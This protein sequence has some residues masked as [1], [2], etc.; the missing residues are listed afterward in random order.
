[1]R[2]QAAQRVA[3]DASGAVMDYIVAA[4]FVGHYLGFAGEELAVSALGRMVGWIAH[5]MEQFHHHDLVRPGASYTGLLPN[6]AV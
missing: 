3:M 5:A 4:L 2:L 1:M 6:G